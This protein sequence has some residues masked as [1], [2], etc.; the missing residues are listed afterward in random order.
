MSEATTSM[1]PGAELSYAS[2]VHMWRGR[3]RSTPMLTAMASRGPKSWVTMSWQSADIRVRKIANGLLSLGVQ[4]GERVAILS[5]TRVEWVLAD[6]AILHA[7]AATTTVYPSNTAE[8]CAY[9]L[10]DCAA[11][12]I[13][14]EN[15]SQMEKVLSQ[16]SELPNLKHIIVLDPLQGENPEAVLSLEDL[17]SAG[18]AH[19][20]AHPDHLDAVLVDISSESLATLI[21]TSGTTGKPKGVRLSH[22]A[23]V[24][25][26]EALD[27]QGIITANDRQFLFLPLSH[28]LAKIAQVAFIRLGVP[29]YIDGDVNRVSALLPE[30]R[31]TFMVAV[32]RVFE[33]AYNRIVQQGTSGSPAK[34]ALFKW[35]LGVGREVSKIKQQHREPPRWLRMRFQ[36][37]DRLVFSKVR[38]AFGGECRFCISGGAPLSKDIAEF[39]H[40]CGL[41]LLEGYGMTES[42]AASTV[43]TP[44]DYIFGTVGRPVPGVEISIADDGEVLIR[45]RTVMQGYHELPEK[46]A[47]TIDQDGWLHTGDLGSLLPS[48]HLQITGRK[49]DLI[50]TAGGKNIA[51]AVFQNQL[52][53]ASPLVGQVLMHGD[54]RNFCVALI[55]L[56][57]DGARAW[58]DE[59]GIGMSSIEELA[60]HEGL[61]NVIQSAVFRVNEGLPRYQTVKDIHICSEPWS[62]ENGLLT[63]SLKVKRSTVESRYADV[64]NAFYAGTIAKS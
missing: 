11:V 23:W 41:L 21:Y 15:E 28:V 6:I 35:A 18:K 62:I 4:P 39:F 36:V 20:A 16:K 49:K 54:R 59:Q 13:F 40:A 19:A 3:V 12:A 26:T 24:Y 42:T 61:R 5:N 46:T 55:T 57:E 17:E 25:I 1:T 8:E 34:A 29:T 56:D 7:G 37:A 44:E 43:N 27:Q 51:P 50:I 31:P 38:M 14:V 32:P 58:A 22:D 52:K 30:V 2:V 9:I 53:A 47:E 45:G 64:L 10:N 48:G 33:K 60:T 63:P